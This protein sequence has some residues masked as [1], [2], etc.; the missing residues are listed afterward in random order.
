MLRLVVGEIF[1]CIVV[2]FQKDT[3]TFQAV[4]S[5]GQ[6]ILRLSV[7]HEQE[8]MYASHPQ[9]ALSSSLSS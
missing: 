5:N 8:G 9:S 3:L 7:I 2:D 1:E 6:R 4:G